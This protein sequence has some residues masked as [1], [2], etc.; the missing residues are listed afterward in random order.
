MELI[1]NMILNDEVD[2]DTRHEWLMSMAMIP[3]SVLVKYEKKYLSVHLVESL[4]RTLD[5]LELL[6]EIN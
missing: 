1:K 5:F 6:V 2:K 4:K 3:R